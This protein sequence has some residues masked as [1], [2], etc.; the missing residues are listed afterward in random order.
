MIPS[1]L[2][3]KRLVDFVSF[4]CDVDSFVDELT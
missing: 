3:D 4:E 1:V 2:D